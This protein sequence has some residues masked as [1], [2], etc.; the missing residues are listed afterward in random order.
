MSSLRPRSSSINSVTQRA[1]SPMKPL[2]VEA[3]NDGLILSDVPQYNLSSSSGLLAPLYGSGS[4]YPSLDSTRPTARSTAGDLLPSPSFSSTSSYQ[5]GS[6]YNPAQRQA[7]ATGQYVPPPPPLPYV[8]PPPPLRSAPSQSNHAG[9]VIPPPPGPPP[10]SNWQ[11]SWGRSY[12]ARGFPL[13]PPNPPGNSQHQAYNPGQNYVAHQPPPLSIPPP[14]ASEHQMSATYIPQGDSFGPGVGIPGFGRTQE[15]SFSRGDSAE[16]SAVS[17][18]SSRSTS[19]N[20]ADTALSTPLDDGSSFYKD[21]DRMYQSQTPVN[22][23]NNIHLPEFHPSGT[24]FLLNT[25][26]SSRGVHQSTSTSN[27]NTPTSPSDAAAQ[28]PMD[29]V[30]LWLSQNSFSTDWQETFR[31]LNISGSGFLE[32]GSGHGGRGN[33]GMMHQQVYPRLAKECSNSGTGWDQARERDEGKRM[34]RLIRSIVTGRPLDSKSSHVRRKSSTANIQSAGTEGTVEGSPNLGRETHVS[35][36]STANGD[37]DSPG[38]SMLKGPG[39]GFGNRRFSGRSTTMP[40]LSNNTQD[41]DT[42]NRT[43]HRNFLRNIDGD[44]SRRH[45]PSAS[46]ETIEGLTLRLEGSPKSGSPGA[47]ANLQGSN[48]GGQPASPHAHTYGHRASNSTDSISSS[49]AIYGSGVPPGISQVLRGGMGG[50]AGDMNPIRNQDSR[51]HG[52]N[53]ARPLPLDT[54]DRSATSEPPTSA[55][56]SKG[57]LKH[58]RKKRKDDGATPSPDELYLESPTSPS[59]SFKPGLFLGNGKNSSETS[60]DRPSSTFSA[61]EYDKFAHITGYRGRRG[62]PGRTFILATLNGLD[63]RI[64]DVTDVDSAADLRSVICSTL[65]I[66]DVDFVQMFLTELGRSEHDEALDDQKLLLYR[67]TKAD[68]SGSLKLY[69]RAPANLA[70]HPAPQSAACGVSFGNKLSLSPGLLPTAPLDEEAYAALHGARRR[71]SSSPPSSRQ[72]TLKATPIAQTGQERSQAQSDAVRDR[73]KQFRSSQQEGGE[74]ELS[75]IDRRIFMEMAISEHKAEMERRQKEYL[76]KKKASKETP[77]ADGPFGIVGRNVDFDQPR[78][79][80]FEDKKLDGL[81]PQRK[82]PP[83]PADSATLLK[84]NSLSKSTGHQTRLSLTSVDSE[85]RRLS[86]GEHQYPAQL[87]EMSEFAR[88]KPV[89]PSP[90][91][92]SGIAAALV[93]MGS[94]LG[95]VGHPSPS[96]APVSSP[97]KRTPPGGSDHFERGRSAMASVEFNS[98]GSSSRSLSGTPGSTTWGKGDTPFTVPDYS[99]GGTV[100]N[101]RNRSLS[102]TMPE[103]TAMNKITEGETTRT[104]SP[105]EISPNSAHATPGM[106]TPGNRK[107]YG[108]NL[109]FT[110]SS[111]DF[112]TPSQQNPPTDSDDDSD[113][114]LFA[115]PIASRKPDKKSSMRRIIAEE[116]NGVDA[117]GI[118]KR[119]SL[120]IKTSRSKKG[121]SVSFTS[122]K[123]TNGVTS[124]ARTPDFEDESARSWGKRAQRRNPGSANSEGGWSAESSEDMSAK[125]LRRESFAREDLWAS[126]PPAEALINHLDDFFPNLDLDQPVVEETTSVSPPISPIAEH[127]T[128][129]QLA[130]AQAGLS[131]GEGLTTSSFRSNLSYNNGNTLGSDESTLKALER[132]DSMHSIAQRNIRRSGGL[133]RM[134]SIREVARGAHEANKRLTAPLSEGGPSSIML[135]R[136]STKMF[137]ANIVQIKPKRGSMILPHIP[138]DNIPKRQATFRWFKGQL[139]GK[140]TYGRV[141]LG[142]NA[143]TGEFLAV[144]QVE[145][146]AKA[147]GNAGNDKEKM[148]EMVA[149]LDQEIDTMQHLDHVNIVQY[150]GCERKE[151]SI[152]I[153]LEYISGGSVGSCLRKHGKFEETVVSSL[154]RQTLS[155]LAY[156]HREGILHRDLKADNILLDLDGTCKISDFGISKKTDNIYGNDSTNNMQGSV[157]WMAPEVVRS[158]GQGYSAKVDIWSL[159]CVVLEMFAGRRPWSK[160]ETVGAIYK[161]GS[162]NE[163][164]P[165]PDDVSMNISPVAVAFMADCFQIDPSERP[166]ADTLLSQ[167]PFCELDPNYNFLDTDFDSSGGE[168]SDYTETSV[169]LGYASKE[170]SE[171]DTISYLGGRSSWL[172]PTTPPSA[173][174]AKCRV[175]SDL[176][177]QLLQLN[178]DLPEYFPG[179]ERRL[180]VL[181][182]R[183]KTCRRKEGSVRVLRGI[184]VSEVASKKKKDTKPAEIKVAKPAVNLGETLFGGSPFSSSSAGF[185]NPFST[186][187]SNPSASS[188]NPASVLAAKSPQAPSPPAAD[189]PK[190][191]ASAL[192]LNNDTAQYGPQPPPEPWPQ[193]SELPTAYP[194][195]YLVDADYETLDKVED[196][197]IPTQTMDVDEGGGSKNQKEDKDVY[198]S[199]IDKTF[200]KFADRLAQNP[201]QVIRYEFKGQPLLYSKN[202]AIGKLLSGVGKENSKVNVASVNG[203]HIPRCV[204]CGAGRVFEVQLTPHVIMELEKEETSIDGMEWGTIIVGVCEKDCQQSG[205]RD[206]VGLAPRASSWHRTSP[207]GNAS[208]DSIPTTTMA[209]KAH[210]LLLRLRPLSDRL[211]LPIF[212]TAKYHSYEHPPPPGPFTPIESSIL[213]ASLPY[214]PSSGFT[215]TSLSLGARDA[216]Y[217]DASINL[218]P[219]GAFSLVHYYLLSQ[220]RGLA[221]RA[222]EIVEG[223]GGVGM[224]VQKLTWERLMANAKVAHRWQEALALMAQPSNIP[225][226]IS[227]LASL[228]DEIWFLAGDTSVDSSWYTKRASLSTIYAATDLFM[229]TD[230][231]PGYAET[232]EFLGRRLKDSQ[233]LGSTLGAVGQ[234][235]GFTASAGLN[236]LRSKGHAIYMTEKDI[237]QARVD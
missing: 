83:P 133:G 194:L 201:E 116:D 161:L 154:T 163:A 63:Y 64:C 214:I 56:E 107:S 118:G 46:G 218:F 101:N 151:M 105:I 206:G 175:C 39:P 97:G 121:L 66:L 57:F 157:F 197:P 234:W 215:L 222:R 177:V 115:V 2:Q 137:G 140:G 88:R 123:N 181:T 42:R 198:E 165:V 120:T 193:D 139:I 162:L 180:Y 90:Q 62:V 190:T 167:H 74:S 44:S 237:C 148:R 212:R 87:Q 136:K 138:Q 37:D 13:P 21:R 10:I 142:M 134:K 32:L 155:G 179:H 132:P 75:D 114:G 25:Q 186:A 22:R 50:A 33:F 224:K 70:P 91:S 199:T 72:N 68:R 156:L 34:R 67:K 209:T 109:D 36:P 182:C 125:L 227:E 216:G 172:D 96:V 153:F 26:P 6:M 124:N 79:S 51:R 171:E 60:L 200:Q 73:L 86:D 146:S 144:K 143:T 35:T 147:A 233:V 7:S 38:K 16:F 235:V 226:A 130:A 117:D 92:G 82:P 168:D 1:L 95:G 94:R 164:P 192:S 61:T 211:P 221:E 127:G 9:V 152:S 48:N 4:P 232:R 183:R 174:L 223:E 17:D 104:L 69:I 99:P 150:L 52:V 8:P 207:R 80:P 149:A 135:R 204:N 128:L 24:G 205:V 166:T 170:A 196:L 53:V 159:G 236:V 158:Q 229:T 78:V 49:T 77:P 41:F 184:R 47:F 55:K 5:P 178:G 119:P 19:R 58:F 84:A 71:S 188:G 185:A 81:L 98:R 31:A 187:S 40:N 203:N 230:K 93:G 189:L 103:N 219:K 213:S 65:G 208:S 122:P 195:Y 111:V 28:W 112:K 126:R 76:A 89:P 106:N 54:G 145:V 220:R 110:E 12:D 113:D 225:T 18:N 29:R 129:E 59:L 27:V 108:P 14:P 3:I 228:S 191:F 20:T 45:S 202:D 102:L 85:S 15:P 23:F 169:L 11:G 217:I 173:A 43:N 160:E 231:S 30:L 176:M 100:A 210:T 131:L 141:Y